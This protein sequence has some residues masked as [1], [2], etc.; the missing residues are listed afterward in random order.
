MPILILTVLGK[1]QNNPN[2]L[3]NLRRKVLP[4]HGAEIIIDSLSIVPNTFNIERINKDQYFLDEINA[5]L[6]WKSLPVDSLITVTYRV[7]PFKLNQTIRE[8]NYDSIRFNFALEPKQVNPLS[9]A[10]LFDFG[11]FMYSG[12]IGRGIAVGNNQNAVVNSSLNLQ[13]NGFIGDSLELSA[14]ISD[15]NI[16]IQ[17]EGNTQNIRDFDKIYMQV[18]KKNWQI[19]FGDID[20]RQSKNYFL[21]FYKRLQGVSFITENNI[22]KKISNSLLVSGAIAKG[23][24]TRNIIIPTEGNQGPYRL[25]SPNNELYFV[26]L[27]STEKVFIDG[28]L[29]IR[30]DDQDYVIDYNTAEITFTPKRLITKDT[31]IQI[32]FEYADRNFLNSQIYL[33]DE[34]NINKK[35]QLSIGAFS[36][37]DARNSPINQQLDN[38]Q[39]QFLSTI[40]NNIDSA[41][42]QNAIPDT[43]DI[44][45]ILYKKI[46]T[47]FNGI[48]DSIFIYSPSKNQQLYNVSFLFVGT[49]KGNYTPQNSSANGRVYKWVS[50]DNFGQKQGDWE[51]V[52]LLITPKKQQ[53]ISL[54]ALY[55]LNK[56]TSLLAES[57]ISNYDVNTFSS[58]DKNDNKGYAGKLFLTHNVPILSS[59]KNGL[60]LISVFGYEYVQDR[61]KPLERL[62]NVEFNRDW[63]LPFIAPLATEHL[64]N[65]S[66]KISDKYDD[67]IKYD[68]TN[69][70][71]SDNYNGLRQSI[72][73]N[74]KYKG[75]K[76]SDQFLLT[77]FSYQNKSGI[78]LR[79]LIDISKELKNVKNILIGLNFSAEK[80]ILKDKLTD[81][82]SL[83]SF[84]Y[85][86]FQVYI[87]T[88]NKRANNWG[89]SYFRRNNQY[90]SAKSL[91]TTDKS[92]NVTIFTQIL[93]NEHH[94]LRLNATYRNLKVLNDT[95]TNLKSEK[96]FVGRAEYNVN[97]WHGLI[98]GIILYELG[99]GQE[100]KREYT[101][102][103]VPAGQGQ[104][105]W[106]DYNGDGIPQL[107][108]FELAVFQDQKKYIKIYTPTNLYVKANYI[109]FNYSIDLNPSAIIFN[110][111]LKTFIRRFTTNSTLQINR[112]GISNKAVDLNP[113][114]NSIP[115]TSLIVLTSFL[116]NS[117]FINRSSQKWGLDIT[118]RFNDTKSLL[119]YGF[120]RRKIN[121]L[122]VKGRKNINRSYSTSI[123]YEISSNELSTPNFSNRNYSILEHSLQPEISYIYKSDFRFSINYIIDRKINKEGSESSV[124]HALSADLKYNVLSNGTINTRLT[125]DNISYK[126]GDANTTTGYEILNGLLP[127]KNILWDVE[128]IKKL[129]GNLEMN[130]QYEGRKPGNTK[131]IHTGRVSIRALF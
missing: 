119:T 118:S 92:D 104:Y 58:K 14:A 59:W 100:Q 72:I 102:I 19:N 94:Q 35:L 38:N 86:I 26:V 13:L 91:F 60:T 116:T 123:K 126:G 52:A 10:P 62:R 8:Y 43:F 61:F 6:K 74:T 4:V 39:K 50:P 113:F 120:E 11:N 27:A 3:S 21:N 76:I 24:F 70:R 40:G 101:Y 127:G 79:P 93:T 46:D 2:S 84:A 9:S 73:H 57:A 78:Y 114:D 16:P 25:S 130:I 28:Q 88:Q 106:I 45:K 54:A 68:I 65:T 20:I 98:N 56:N 122:T 99:A 23:K 48:H 89:V 5:I 131:V 47:I 125:Y 115:D 111:N 97:K 55:R 85:N 77:N 29:L 121:D 105:T 112:K 110:P 80:N 63:G 1:A 96:S 51:P 82:L 37:T 83:Q 33:S 75:F 124:N 53:L 22:N 42:F 18:K 69:Y 17:P 87:K 31:R 108:E 30:G 129:A 95:L 32:E 109:Q 81:S 107:N 41:R 67:D 36:N 34:I 44:N 117:L 7:F 49:G 15:N 12:S 64:I 103:E 128:L 71:R 66:I 90:P